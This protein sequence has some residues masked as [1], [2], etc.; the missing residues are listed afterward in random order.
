MDTER[1]PSAEQEKY[2]ALAKKLMD[3]QAVENEGRGVNC[4]REV[5]ISLERGNLEDAR[6]VARTDGDKIR[7][8]P[9]IARVIRD[10]L[11]DGD[12]PQFSEEC[13]GGINEEIYN[14]RKQN[15]I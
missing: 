4:V 2:D 5:A 7:G 14:S 10:E 11:F 12:A 3:L 6:Q 1:V 9:P 13:I 15:K 8:Y